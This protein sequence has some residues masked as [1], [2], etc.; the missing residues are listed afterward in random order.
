MDEYI[1]IPEEAGKMKIES[2][3]RSDTKKKQ[4]QASQLLDLLEQEF[5]PDDAYCT[6]GLMNT[7][8]YPRKGWTFSKGSI[9]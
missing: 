3:V 7:D 9:C 6:I 4:Y 8:L 2:R 1:N 5:V